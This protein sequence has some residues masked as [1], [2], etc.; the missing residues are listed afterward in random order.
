[1][2][3]TKLALFLIICI[4]CILA[5]SQLIYSQKIE[6][7]REDGV[8]VIYNPK[9]PVSLSGV[10]TRLILKEEFKIGEKEGREEYMFSNI[11]FDV[12]QEGNI[13]VLDTRELNI[14]I[15]D[16]KGKFLR[17]FGKGG[18]GPGEFSSARFIQITPQRE[19]MIHD[20][21][22]R[23]LIFFS[24]KGKYLRQLRLTNFLVFLM[25]RIDSKGN[26]IGNAINRDEKGIKINF[27]KFD[28]LKNIHV[29][30]DKIEIPFSKYKGIF[31][32]IFYWEIKEKDK[33]IYGSPNKYELKILNSDGTLIKKIIKKYEP[34]KITEEDK[35]EIIKEVFGKNKVP[36]NEKINFPKYFP[37]FWSI[38]SD[39]EGRIFVGTYEK[40]K[41]KK[42][43]YYF[44]V[45]ER[46]GRYIARIPLKI[47]SKQ[48]FL[49]KNKRLYV[50]EETEGGF[51]VIKCYKAIW[52]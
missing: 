45:F 5:N 29:V 40:V 32:P 37:V 28:L 12:D 51:P 52:R 26:I 41:D 2:K 42:G 38:S 13:Y 39:E 47:N 36:A 22:A 6:I 8:I 24:L 48:W 17:I 43:Y 18:Q 9:T 1:M 23:R 3:K 10:P 50:V 31:R 44:D 25:P 15:F 49:W 46:E 27:I 21:Y 16:K 11:I 14:K 34:I 20:L 35:N 30:L 33:V 4:V 19:I 7:K